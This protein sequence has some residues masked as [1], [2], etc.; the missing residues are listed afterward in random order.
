MA[1]SVTLG[2]LVTR[3][4]QRC[5]REGDNSIGTSEWKALISASY[6][7]MH[8]LVV[9]AGARL[10]Q[11]EQ[12]ITADG[13]PSYALPADHLHTIGVDFVLDGAGRRRELAEIAVQERTDWIGNTGDAYGFALVGSTIELYPKPSSG[14]YKHVYAPQPTDYSASADGTSVDVINIHGEEFIVW[15]VASVAQH[16]GEADQQRAMLERD[17]AKEELLVWAT[18]RSLH[19]HARQVNRELGDSM[20]P[21]DWW[22]GR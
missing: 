9:D 7:R 13:S 5:D 12:T 22:H 1:R 14:T 18:R 20:D 17:R 15:D 6:A 10:F 8:A 16:K 3:C 11:S 2:T 4:Q 19:N 21:A